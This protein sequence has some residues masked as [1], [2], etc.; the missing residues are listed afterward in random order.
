MKRLLEEKWE[1]YKES[2][3]PD[4][5]PDHQIADMRDAFFIGALSL[6]AMLATVTASTPEE[7]MR[8]GK[9][10]MNDV[11]HELYDFQ[12]VIQAQAEAERNEAH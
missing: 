9:Q 2:C 3:I 7:K 12:N 1:D 10:L 4:A 6:Y 8:V 5:A 11:H